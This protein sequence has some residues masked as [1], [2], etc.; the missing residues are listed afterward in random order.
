MT[1]TTHESD[2]SELHT[3]EYADAEQTVTFNVQFSALCPF[4]HPPDK[5]DLTV[6]YRGTTGVESDSLERYLRQ[7]RT[8]ERTAEA[9]AAAI[10]ADLTDTLD[11]EA[12][13]VRLRQGR[14]GRSQLTVERGTEV[15]A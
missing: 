3:L 6:T 12:L 15:G 1:D 11:P 7:Y 14:Q 2:P 10:H 9:L 13:H 5:Y 4:D 8:E